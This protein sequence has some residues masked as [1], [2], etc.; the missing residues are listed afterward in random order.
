[1]LLLCLSYYHQ[2]YSNV[3]FFVVY[4]IVVDENSGILI[5][6]KHYLKL[7]LKATEFAHRIQ[8]V[9]GY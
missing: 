5:M 7:G 2:Y 4:I 3:S 1:M 6:F 9:K 8:E